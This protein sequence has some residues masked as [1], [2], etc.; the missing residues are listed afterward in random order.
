MFAAAGLMNVVSGIALV[1]VVSA[2]SHI[3]WF[4]LFA[5]VYGIL[6]RLH[7]R[8]IVKALLPWRA[9]PFGRREWSGDALVGS[10]YLMLSALLLGASLVLLSSRANAT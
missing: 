8:F 9:V 7:H 4:A 5:V 6:Y 3:Q 1:D 10:A 2:L